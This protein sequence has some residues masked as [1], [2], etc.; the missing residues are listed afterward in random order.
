MEFIVFLC[1][2]GL[3]A[4]CAGTW[5]LIQLRKEDKK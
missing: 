1:F 5:A 2:I 3:V 4:G